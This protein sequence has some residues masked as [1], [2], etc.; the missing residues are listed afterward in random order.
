MLPPAHPGSHDL[1]RSFAA[2]PHPWGYVR[3][4]RPEPAG[5]ESSAAGLIHSVVA[6]HAGKREPSPDH[7]PVAKA[8]LAVGDPVATR[9]TG[10]VG[11]GDS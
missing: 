9:T 4:N 2:E 6:D 11:R 8:A 3:V 1:M 5:F 10:G 7:D